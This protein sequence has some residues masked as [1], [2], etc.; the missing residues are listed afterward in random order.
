MN[1][2]E[3]RKLFRREAGDQTK[4]Y[5]W[6]DA[7]IAEFANEAEREACRRADLLIDSQT[8]KLCR[9][10]VK[11]GREG[12]DI[13]KS[14]IDIRR[15]RIQGQGTSVEPASAA[16]MDCGYGDWESQTGTEIL[17]YLPD[18]DTAFIRLY[19]I[20]LQDIVLRMTVQRMPL[21]EMDSDDDEPEILWRHH[22]KLVYWMLKL[23]Y[24]KQDSEGFDADK[25]QRAEAEFIREFGPSKS[26]RNEQWQRMTTYGLPD[27]LV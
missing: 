26:A 20:P 24:E 17:Y 10:T 6:S 5:L 9:V 21:S 16:E 11:A 15:M 25:A 23:A 13:D 4:P 3:L 18:M 22:R 14:V 27:A 2:G 7:E 19:P 1:L 8:Q 12:F